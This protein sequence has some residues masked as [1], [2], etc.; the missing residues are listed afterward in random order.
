[1]IKTMSLDGLEMWNNW[2]GGVKIGCGKVKI[3]LGLQ[4]C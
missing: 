2:G 3:D 1:M 4:G